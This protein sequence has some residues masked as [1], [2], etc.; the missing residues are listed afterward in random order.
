MLCRS[1]NPLSK[2]MMGFLVIKYSYIIEEVSLIKASEIA[3]SYIVSLTKIFA[4][5]VIYTFLMFSLISQNFNFGIYVLSSNS[6]T[7]ELP[8]FVN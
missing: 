6:K 2:R 7:L 4:G 1:L 3:I 5:F 8:M